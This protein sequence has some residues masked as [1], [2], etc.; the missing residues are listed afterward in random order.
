MLSLNIA[1]DEDY[2]HFTDMFMTLNA[3]WM[4]EHNVT[5]FTVKY[6]GE[7]LISEDLESGILGDL[8]LI[9]AI[10]LPLAFAALAY[11]LGS[12]RLL[13]VPLM[14]VPSTIVVAFSIMLPVSHFTTV[15]SFAPE[16][17]AACMMAVSI[18]YSLF[19]L[20]RFVDQC[21]M[22]HANTPPS[23]PC[24]GSTHHTTLLHWLRL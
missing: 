20:S 19:I 5:S 2:D 22:Q 4:S 15:S 8:A 3:K 13:L 21:A 17:A 10:S 23:W 7:E 12:V 24:C 6:T 9:D 14:T 1:E 18:D 11:C 16:M